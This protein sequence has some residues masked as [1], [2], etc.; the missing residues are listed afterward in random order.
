MSTV[1]ILP[2]TAASTM[3]HRPTIDT[4]FEQKSNIQDTIY[5]FP[6][7]N[8]LIRSHHSRSQFYGRRLLQ[9]AYDGGNH[10]AEIIAWVD[11]SKGE[12]KEIERLEDHDNQ[13]FCID[14]DGRL[15]SKAHP[16]CFV[17]CRLN[18]NTKN[19]ELA[20]Q[21]CERQPEDW[22]QRAC[23]F[24][25]DGASKAI[26]VWVPATGETCLEKYS[27]TSSAISISSSHSERSFTEMVRKSFTLELM[28]QRRHSTVVRLWNHYTGSKED[29][30]RDHHEYSEAQA[31]PEFIHVVDGSWHRGREIRVVAAQDTSGYGIPTTMFQEWDIIPL[32]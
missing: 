12:L 4:S 1:E 26:T 6:T 7:G 15:R 25:Y 14:D 20:L 18:P 2:M 8:F 22:S 19:F 11:E 31:T 21:S 29:E 3:I 10:A 27:D 13:V 28:P 24:S 32:H 9:V 5:G 17:Y 16:G 23:R 30:E